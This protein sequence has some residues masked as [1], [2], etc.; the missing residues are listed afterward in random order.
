MSCVWPHCWQAEL[1]CKH[2]FTFWSFLHDHTLSCALLPCVIR[3]MMIVVP[4]YLVNE[5]QACLASDS[6]AKQTTESICDPVHCA[7][8]L[9][10][11]SLGTCHRGASGSTAVLT[12]AALIAKCCLIVI[13]CRLCQQV[14]SSTASCVKTGPAFEFTSAKLCPIAVNDLVRLLVST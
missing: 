7:P 13:A 11:H 9:Q 14:D 10:E 1:K 2:I 8:S 6:G 5:S 3:V 4:A 12:P